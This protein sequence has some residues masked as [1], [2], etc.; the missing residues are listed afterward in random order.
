MVGLFMEGT[1]QAFGYPGPVHSGASVIAMQEGVPVVPCGIDSFGWSLKNAAAVRCRRRRPGRPRW[2]PRNGRGYKE[3]AQILEGELLRLW[4]QAAQAVADGFPRRASGWNAAPALAA[5]VG[6][7]S[8]RRGPSAWPTEDWAE[9]AA[10]PA[11]QGVAGDVRRA[12]REPARRPRR[13]GRQGDLP[14]RRPARGDRRGRERDPW[15]RPRGRHRVCDRCR[16]GSS[17]SRSSD[18]SRRRRARGRARFARTRSAARAARLR[19]RGHRDAPCSRASWPARRARFEL[20]GDES[21]S[22]RPQ[23]RIA[24]PLR[25]MGAVVETT[26]GH[27]PVTIEGRPLQPNPLRAPGRERPGEVGDP[28]RR[29]LRRGRSDDRRRA[30]ADARPHRADADGDG[31]SGRAAAGRG[32]RLAGRA[33]ASAL[34]GRVRGHLV[35]GAVHRRGHAAPGFRA[36]ASTAS[37]STRREPALST[38]SSGWAR[39]SRSTTG[40]P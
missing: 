9:G 24:V 17:E 4:R 14:A 21:L 27:A 38:C 23:E 32:E 26:D 40:G 19:Q 35:R 16:A 29:A 13:P 31:C 22:S 1:R 28:P 20:V 39:G 2:A 33:P 36:A 7:V 10:R 6:S 3:G 8:A 30:G 34:A 12:R 18:V 5:D 37:T 11:L 25:E 15:L